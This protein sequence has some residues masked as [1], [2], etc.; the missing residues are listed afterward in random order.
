MER[1]LGLK[2]DR[3]MKLFVLVKVLHLKLKQRLASS[4]SSFVGVKNQGKIQGRTREGKVNMQ[5]KSDI[6]DKLITF[7]TLKHIKLLKFTILNNPIQLITTF[8]THNLI[9]PRNQ[10]FLKISTI[11]SA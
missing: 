9:L 2:E 6:V 1:E 3:G 4:P 8:S 5:G 7:Q 11:L 10:F